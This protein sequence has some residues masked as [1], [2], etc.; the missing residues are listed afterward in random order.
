MCHEMLP[1]LRHVTKHGDLWSLQWLEVRIV[2][3][4]EKIEAA[5][6]SFQEVGPPRA[7]ISGNL[8]SHR[9]LFGI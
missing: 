9:R 2:M 4:V 1:A 7:T 8:N 3:I 5:R 6:L